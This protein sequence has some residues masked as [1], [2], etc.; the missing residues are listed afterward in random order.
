MARATAQVVADIRVFRPSGED[1]RQLDALL[2]ELWATGEPGRHIRDLLDVLE[3]FPEE[4]GDGVLWSIVHGL[5][6]LPGYE[7]E[8]VR[9]VQRRP[10]EFGLMMVGRLLN[11]GESQVAGTSL[12]AL[13]RSVGSDSDVPGRVRES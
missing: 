5:E 8:L 12:V 9:S 3:R 11:S 1:W 7:P 4:D 10:S 6:S 13:L 2:D